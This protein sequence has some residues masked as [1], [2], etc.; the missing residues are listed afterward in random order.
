MPCLPPSRLAPE[1][2]QL[3]RNIGG[4]AHIRFPDNFDVVFNNRFL[5]QELVA[6]H[7]TQRTQMP[8][9]NR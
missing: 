4:T 1:L 8:F 9:S 5:E 2:S 6:W 7:L 3:K